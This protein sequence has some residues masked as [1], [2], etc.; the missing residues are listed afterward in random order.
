[1]AL[2]VRRGLD[3]PAWAVR[4]AVDPAFEPPTTVAAE[5]LA[6]RHLGRELLHL[7]FVARGRK[8]STGCSPRRR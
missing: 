4:L 6:A 1:M 7:A 3:Y 8:N 2:A 5:H